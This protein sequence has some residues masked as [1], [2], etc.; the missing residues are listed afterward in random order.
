MSEIRFDKLHEQYVIM[1]PERL[2]RPNLGCK[3]HKSSLANL[4]CPFCEGNEDLTPC[5]I[6]AMRENG[7]NEPHWKTRVVPN[8]YKAVQVE[9]NEKSKRDGLFE[10]IPGIGAH[11]ILIDSPNHEAKLNTMQPLEI[12]N[13][14]RSMIIR[15]E[16]LK[17]DQ[18]LI[19][20]SIFKNYGKN[21]GATQ[22]HPHTQLLAL[23]IMPKDE[24]RFLEKNMRYYKQHGRG[25]V[26]DIVHNEMLTKERIVAQ[27]GNFVA[28]CPYASAF[29]FEVMIAPLSNI[30]TLSR[31]SRGELSSL[32][33]LIKRVFERLNN[34]LGNFAYNLSF[35]MA[36][37]NR[38]F[39]NESYMSHLEHNYRFIVRITPR[40]YNFAGFEIATSMAINSVLPEECAKMLAGE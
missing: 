16:D 23:P 12:E 27:Q 5:E 21:A 3:E 32:S 25:L 14:L 24:M 30:T 22:E 33:M 34:Q 1:A 26:E 15:M 29:P 10:S 20:L 35:K 8:L 38:N 40:I 13:W 36:P 28:F 6:F 4:V 17:N 31:C 18:R 2:Y 9:L 11:E 7:E 39:E 19:Y 37:L